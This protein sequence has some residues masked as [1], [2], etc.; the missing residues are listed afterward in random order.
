[1]QLKDFAENLEELQ[2]IDIEFRYDVNLL[3]ITDFS[4]YGT[5]LWNQNYEITHYNTIVE[6][7]NLMETKL[8]IFFNPP[9]STLFN[10]IVFSPD[11]KENIF[12]IQLETKFILTESET[13]KI[14]INSLSLNENSIYLGD[15]GEWTILLTPVAGCTD[16]SACGYN[17][18]ATLDDGSCWRPIEGCICSD[19]EGAVINE[20]DKCEI[21]QTGNDDCSCGEDNNRQ[22]DCNGDCPPDECMDEFMEGSQAG[23]F[24]SLYRFDIDAG[25]TFIDKGSG[26][27]QGEFNF[28]DV[29][30][31]TQTNFSNTFKRVK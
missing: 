29:D 31:N 20:C 18:F 11:E 22:L 4:L 25:E 9:N 17:S 10:P 8:T 12:N 2:S 19:G 14:I 1:M 30:F 16:P 5:V 28:L 24:K 23:T 3:E 26:E 21:P 7:P 15:W 6:E 13:T 27:M